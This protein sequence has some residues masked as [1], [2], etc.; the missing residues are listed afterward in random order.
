MKT[1]TVYDSTKIQSFDELKTIF[2]Y[3]DIGIS[4][5]GIIYQDWQ[6]IL[7][8]YDILSDYYRTSDELSRIAELCWNFIEEKY[9][10]KDV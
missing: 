8:L 9:H 4:I 7:N 5:D 6:D 10:F 3:R 1:L 2:S